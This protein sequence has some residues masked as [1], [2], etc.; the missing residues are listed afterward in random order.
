MPYLILVKTEGTGA[1]LDVATEPATTYCTSPSQT[2][3]SFWAYDSGSNTT[4]DGSKWTKSTS[5]SQ[6]NLVPVGGWEVG[7]RPNMVDITFYKPTSG[8]G[9]N[10]TLRIRDTSF[11]NVATLNITPYSFDTQY[12]V[13]VP[14]AFGS[15]DIGYFN[16]E[17][18]MYSGLE[19]RCIKFS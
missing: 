11:N 4:W 15:D 9:S 5:G 17:E 12:T 3:D 1:P 2:S 19:I 7:L 16:I 13:S 8:N 6:A 14:M 10:G 18:Y